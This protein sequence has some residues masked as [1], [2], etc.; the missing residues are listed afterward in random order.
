MPTEIQLKLSKESTLSGLA[1][2]KIISHK[3]HPK[4][5]NEGKK[6][7]KFSSLAFGDSGSRSVD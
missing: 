6:E 2:F 5:T 3:T 1:L 4:F 7:E